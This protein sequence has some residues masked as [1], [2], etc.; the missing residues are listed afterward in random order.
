M[1]EDASTVRERFHCYDC[2]I[3]I[4]P[5]M[6]NW[7]ECSDEFVLSCTSVF[8]YDLSRLFEVSS[9]G[10]FTWGDDGLKSE[11]IPCFVSDFSRMRFSHWKL[12]DGDPKE[13]KANVALIFSKGMGNF[14]F[15]QLEFQT[16]VCQ[17]ACE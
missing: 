17:P 4:C 6:H 1:K 12:S 11:Q 7:I 8:L 3:I 15:A 13:L 16:H 14:G 10:F 9:D 2:P 5:S